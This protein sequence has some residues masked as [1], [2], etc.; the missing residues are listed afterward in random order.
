MALVDGLLL[1]AWDCQ[2]RGK[3]CWRFSITVAAVWC[4]VYR[5]TLVFI[6]DGERWLNRGRRGKEEEER[7]G[8]D[9]ERKDKREPKTALGGFHLH[10]QT[11]E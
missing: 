8:E 1:L 3:L 2:A 10:L 11:L 5:H 7:L 4:C 9:R 6:R